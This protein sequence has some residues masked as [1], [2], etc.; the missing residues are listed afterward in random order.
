MDKFGFVWSIIEKDGF[1]YISTPPFFDRACPSSITTDAVS[2]VIIAEEK[3]ETSAIMLRKKMGISMEAAI[4]EIL[5]TTRESSL[6][7]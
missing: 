6:T 1:Y 4:V 2:S 3:A 5:G 7:G